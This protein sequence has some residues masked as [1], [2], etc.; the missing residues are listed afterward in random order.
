MR[1][2]KKSRFRELDRVHENSREYSLLNNSTSSIINSSFQR[3]RFLLQSKPQSKS[4]SISNSLQLL[5]SCIAAYDK[6]W[7]KSNY[8]AW[9]ALFNAAKMNQIESVLHKI[10]YV[11]V[12]RTSNSTKWNVLRFRRI[13]IDLM[14]DKFEDKIWNDLLFW[15]SHSK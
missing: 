4:F 11:E 9:Q 2:W 6:Y 13:S 10:L 1:I 14:F 8:E 5:S 3:E 7:N 12:F 15:E